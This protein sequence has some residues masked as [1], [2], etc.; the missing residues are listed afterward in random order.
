MMNLLK[1]LAGVLT[2]AAALTGAI[3]LTKYYGNRPE[4]PPPRN[5][6][7]HAPS[8]PEPPATPAADAAPVLFKPHLITLNFAA[9]QSHTTVTLERDRSRPAPERLWVW[10]YFFQPGAGREG[11]GRYCA[12]DPVE[13]RQPFA[14]GDRAT[15]TVNAPAHGCPAPDT[16]SA[17]FYARVNVST[18][19]ASAA[20]LGGAQISYDLASATPVVVQG[21]PTKRR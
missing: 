7:T 6:V 5:V 11:Q 18:E 16:P 21:V 12:D 4:P 13:V 1:K 15:V 14:S 10:T 2:F 17:T 19:S 3:V 20:R 8:P 9:R